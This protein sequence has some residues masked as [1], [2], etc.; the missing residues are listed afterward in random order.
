[1]LKHLREERGRK[2]EKV[3]GLAYLYLEQYWMIKFQ[4]D[5]KH[6][7]WLV[8]FIMLSITYSQKLPV[9]FWKFIKHSNI[10]VTLYKTKKCS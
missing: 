4:I 9:M 7:Y 1:M 2:N 10:N 6:V 8:H 5:V 3:E